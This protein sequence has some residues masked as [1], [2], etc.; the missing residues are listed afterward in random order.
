MKKIFI[1]VI[2][3]LCFIIFNNN[4][5]FNDDYYINILNK[6]TYYDENNNKI[7]HFKEEIY[8]QKDVINYID[9]ND[10]V[11]ELGGRYG[12]VSVTVSYVQKNSGNLVV[13]EPDK[14][15]INAL[16]NNKLRNNANF[17]ILN[18]YISNETK[19]IIYDSYGTRTVKEDFGDTDNKITYDEFKK[20]FPLKF[21]VLIADCEGC[22]CDFINI[23]GDD[24]NNYNKILLEADQK[25][26]CEY[27]KVLE[28]LQKIGF[29]IVKNEDDVR[30]VLLK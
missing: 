13:V 2:L 1:F 25:N 16:K 24:I 10:I 17:T 27:N 21:N 15:I 28:K 6:F 4:S 18:K 22:F 7:D 3:I 9:K 14:T 30:Y 12:T 11:L 8:E 29:R 20:Q 19:K 23:M 5:G 26:I